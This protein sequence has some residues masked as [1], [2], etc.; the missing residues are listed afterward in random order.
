MTTGENPPF[1]LLR[2]VYLALLSQLSMLG[3]RNL[4]VLVDTQIASLRR[5]EKARQT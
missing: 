1:Q 5:I 3:L 2:W 4:T